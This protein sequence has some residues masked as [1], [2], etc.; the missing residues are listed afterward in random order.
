MEDQLFYESSNDDAWSLT[1]DPLS[2]AP[3][4]MHRPNAPSGGKE[5]YTDVDKFLRESPGGPQH[6]AL[7]RRINAG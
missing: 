5:S 4:V 1:R 3:A 2:G 7:R 6:Q